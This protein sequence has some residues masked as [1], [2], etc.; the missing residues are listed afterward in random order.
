MGVPTWLNI[1]VWCLGEGSGLSRTEMERKPWG[2]TNSKE[3]KRL[4]SLGCAEWGWSRN[5]ML[6]H[7]TEWSHSPA[8]NLLAVGA[9]QG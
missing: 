4:P 1:R 3:L 6:S 7:M 5:G 9:G 2:V 8:L